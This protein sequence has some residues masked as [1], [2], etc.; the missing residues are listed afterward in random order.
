[1]SV[2]ITENGFARLRISIPPNP[3]KVLAFAAGELASCLYRISR[4]GTR[5]L[6]DGKNGPGVI[7]LSAGNEEE[8]DAFSIVARDSSISIHGS[9]PRAALFGVYELLERAGCVFAGPFDEFVPDIPTLEL[10]D[11]STEQTASFDRRSVYNTLLIF[12][13][14]VHFDGFAP[15][16]FLPQIAWLAKRKLNTFVFSV[17]FNRY[18]LWDS[19]RFQAAD[20]LEKRGLKILLLNASVEYFFPQSHAQD[21]GDYG[22][23]T[24]ASEHPEYYDGNGL[25]RIEM[26]AVR[27]IV[28]ERCVDFIVSHAELES[29]AL[30]PSPK[31]LAGILNRDSSVAPF[32]ELFN[33]TARR[34]RVSAPDKKLPVLLHG[35]LL[36]LPAGFAFEKNVLPLFSSA[37][38][39]FHYNC[40]SPVNAKEFARG[41][42]WTAGIPSV[43]ID[44]LG[45]ESPLTPLAGT[46][47]KN[48]EAYKA[49]G[50]SG[51]FAHAGPSYNFL[52]ARNRRAL[53]FYVYSG[54]LWNG[55]QDVEEYR[56]QWLRGMFGEAAGDMREFYR[57]LEVRHDALSSQYEMKSAAPWIDLEFCHEAQEVLDKARAAASSERI[58]D[59][60]DAVNVAMLNAC[61]YRLCPHGVPPEDEFLR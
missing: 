19:F 53:D 42:Q 58:R 52:G 26:P 25:L 22:D 60:I 30:S 29:A 13:R 11:F 35:A 18:D 41:K 43:W 16:R 27:R 24:Y 17:D 49:L 57:L 46:V 45:A 47:R 51:A 6:P 48:L 55:D 56:G 14:S 36:D 5:I 28:A 8:R 9:N 59:R 1:M 44:H 10:E 38:V 21:A 3:G 4:A 32:F 39:D 50:V 20:E 61:V 15:E 2:K 7:A 54:L 37:A 31:L 23:S 34:L 12:N 40:R 33:E